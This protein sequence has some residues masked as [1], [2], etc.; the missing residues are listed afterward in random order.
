[1]NSKKWLFLSK[2]KQR[3]LSIL[4]YLLFLFFMVKLIFEENQTSVKITYGIMLVVF[5]FFAF[6][7]EFLKWLYDKATLT[8]IENCDPKQARYYIA[9]LDKYDFFSSY[10]TSIH[11]FNLLSL[12]DLGQQDDIINYLDIAGKKCFSSSFDLLLVYYYSLFDA[13]CTLKNPEKATEFYNHLMNL[14]GKKMGLKRISP[15]FSWDEIEAQHQ[16]LIGNN[17]N[18][19]HSLQLVNLHSMNQREQV[20]YN[21]L[22]AKV[23]YALKNFKT[24][25]KHIDF[26]LQNGGTMKVVEEAKVLKSKR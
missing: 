25:Y 5:G 19:K 18:S 6:Y 23:E 11:I 13:Y 12:R 22:C 21:L 16:Y 4:I 14:K 9:Q 15:L 24:A 20:Y 8:L 7:Y 2:K 1:M 3:F 10:K 17:K 26:I